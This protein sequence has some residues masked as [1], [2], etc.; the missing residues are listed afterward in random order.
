MSSLR[1]ATRYAKA[2]FQLSG[3]KIEEAEKTFAS[4]QAVN[5]LFSI[6]EAARVLRSPVMP[7]ALKRS[8]VEL[9]LSKVGK[10]ATLANFADTLSGAG[11]LALFPQVVEAYET[12]L[13][14]AKGILHAEVTAAVDLGESELNAVRTSL[15]SLLGSEVRVTQKADPSILGGFV[16]RIGNMLIDMSVKTKLNGLANSALV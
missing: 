7:A 10:D 8:L 6:D 12:L 13:N 11:R 16:V 15:R 5:Q 3:G 2:L 9:A 4:L 1:I 14:A